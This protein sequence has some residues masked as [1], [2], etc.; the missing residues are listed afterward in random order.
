MW[1]S[2]KGQG[3]VK[4]VLSCFDLDVDSAERVPVSRWSARSAART[5]DL[6]GRGPRGS[7][8]ARWESESVSIGAVMWLWCNVSTVQRMVWGQGRISAAGLPFA[9][10]EGAWSGARAT[11]GVNQYG[12][13]AEVRG[14]RLLGGRA[15]VASEILTPPPGGPERG[16]VRRAA[17]SRP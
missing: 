1:T 7:A 10:Q 3:V 12:D 8:H 9:P 11:R 4:G 14:V 5:N 15:R 6:D 16:C 13:R 2:L 17:R